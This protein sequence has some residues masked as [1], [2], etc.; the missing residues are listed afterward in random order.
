MC[1]IPQGGVWDFKSWLIFG[2]DLEYTS[3][4]HCWGSARYNFVT[5]TPRDGQF[6]MTLF[7]RTSASVPCIKLIAP[8]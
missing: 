8:Y 2:A 4:G 3:V 7:P 5:T 1:R 6:V